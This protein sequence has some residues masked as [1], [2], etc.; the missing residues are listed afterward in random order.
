MSTKRWGADVP[1]SMPEPPAADNPIMRTYGGFGMTEGGITAALST[2]DLE[3]LLINFFGPIGGE[4]DGS[5]SP[6]P[7]V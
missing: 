1:V 3:E 4:T 6:E 5:D 7:S 2:A